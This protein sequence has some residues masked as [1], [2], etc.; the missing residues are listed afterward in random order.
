[1]R[2]PIEIIGQI[3]LFTTLDDE[4]LTHIAMK[5]IERHYERGE[6]ILYE[7]DMGGSLY[8]LHTG[9]VKVFKTSTEGKEQI[10]RLITG[11]YTFND[12][13]ALDGGPNPASV[14][15]IEP[16]IIYSIKSTELHAL[17]KSRSEVADA[18]V[19]TLA[20]RLRHLVGLAQE[21]SLHHVTAR[22]AKILL[23]EQEMLRHDPISHRLTQ[24]EIA[25]LAGT[26]REVVGRALKS[27]EMSGAIR[28]QQGHVTIINR[29]QLEMIVEGVVS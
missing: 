25:S 1:M 20:G 13:A 28:V 4:E 3:P 8:Y 27:L 15:A 23:H 7:G 18:V 21:L 19:Q 17:I 22:V 29:K 6:S 26:A 10:L 24:Q 12:V 5:T 14:A 9:L 16:S 2:I 11:G